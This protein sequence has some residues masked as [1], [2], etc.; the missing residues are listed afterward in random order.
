MCVCIRAVSACFRLIHTGPYLVV[1]DG[2]AW[3]GSGSHHLDHGVCFW[4][5]RVSITS[6]RTSFA[7][8]LQYFETGA[9]QH[10]R[11]LGV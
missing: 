1:L 2:A 3:S 5:L 10:D 11:L 7:L 8:L 6:F 9:C 4:W